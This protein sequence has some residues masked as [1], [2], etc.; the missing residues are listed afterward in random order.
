MSTTPPTS[1]PAATAPRPSIVQLAIKEKAA[2]YAAYIPL[3]K[4]GGIF[5]PTLREYNLGDDI[6]VL[7]T[8]PDDIQRYP[9]AGKV[10]WVTPPKASGNRTQ[11]V[12]I[13]FPA[14]EKSRILK[15]KIEQILGS[16]LGSERPT[17]TI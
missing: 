12:G 5:I 9:V 11:G 8:I 7:L 17:Q 13:R 10:A 4:E 14:D 15:V 6:Y 16:S 1:P 2:L 3:F